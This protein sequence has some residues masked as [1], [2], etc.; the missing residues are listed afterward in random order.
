M[1]RRKQL[2]QTTIAGLLSAE[3]KKILA[4]KL[5][6]LCSFAPKAHVVGV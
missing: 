3:D 2:G 4:L 5:T 6:V 1:G